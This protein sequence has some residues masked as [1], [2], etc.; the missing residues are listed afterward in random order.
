MDKVSSNYHGSTGGVSQYG[1][2][3]QL[4]VSER[5][6][7]WIIFAVAVVFAYAVLLVDHG[8]NL[9]RRDYFQFYPL[10][11]LC[12]GALIADHFK[13]AD[14]GPPNT[15]RIGPTSFLLSLPITVIAVLLPSPL[16]AAISFWLLGNGLLCGL[17]DIRRAWRLL[18]LLLPLPLGYDALLV[19]RLQRIA[20]QYAGALLDALS[21]PHLM[22]GNVLE[23]PGR[24]FFVEEACSGI[25]SVYLLL[26]TTLFFLV[27]Q[28]T[29]LVRAI[30][31]VVSV[32]WWAVVGNVVH[33]AAIA[34]CWQQWQLDLATGWPHDVLGLTTLGFAF[35]M[36]WLTACFF[37]GILAPV[38][39]GDAVKDN[40]A[41]RRMT[42]AVLWNFFTVRS[43][44]AAYGVTEKLPF[45]WNIRRRLLFYPLSA[46]LCL[47]GTAKYSF[48][49]AAKTLVS[50]NT[51]DTVKTAENT[52]STPAGQEKFD[53]LSREFFD[54]GTGMVV[55]S[56]ELQNS[57]SALPKTESVPASKVWQLKNLQETIEFAVTGPIYE[58]H[59]LRRQYEELGWKVLS[60]ENQILRGAEYPNAVSLHITD[61]DGVEATL[62]YCIFASSGD[63]VP[64]A[65]PALGRNL[66][67]VFRNRL[68]DSLWAD[69]NAETW[70]VRMLVPH[71]AMVSEPQFDFEIKKF[72]RLLSLVTA[73]WRMQ[74]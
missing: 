72:E 17:P 56:F 13:S 9:W 66:S 55:E 74:P 70:L 41:S 40:S 35:F 27:L 43:R 59:D 67:Q 38:G 46:F 6:R 28:R 30:P 45:G 22:R 68:A 16:L 12:I 64:L 19:T 4:S 42:P 10:F 44:I 62:H 33:I 8:R 39:K 14:L 26:S 50:A 25:S 58:S 31:L 1:Q 73:H 15:W 57:L 71:S 32:L 2:K 63:L 21:V 29:R 52:E 51:F 37:E 20:S 48:D 18:C 5:R 11:L 60:L 53:S 65:Q 49:Y 7:I 54:S 47:A 34:F 69:Q 24:K 36:I 61:V 23:L 3:E